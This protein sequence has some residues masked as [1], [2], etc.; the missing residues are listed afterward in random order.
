[1]LVDPGYIDESYI[2]T[3]VPAQWN[4]PNPNAVVLIP[5][6]QELIRQFYPGTK[7]SVSEWSS[8]DDTDITGG[9]VTVDSLGIFGVNGLDQATYW[10]QPD[11]LG[12]IGLAFWLYR[13][14]V[15]P[16]SSISVAEVP[17]VAQE[18]NVLR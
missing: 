13:G 1:M 2:G 3:S 12:P 8:T 10:T 17:E 9:L 6:M 5:R 16:S 7:L 14:Y 11:Q 15:L 4:E 18:W